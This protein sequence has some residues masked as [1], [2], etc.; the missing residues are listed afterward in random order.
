MSPRQLDRRRRRGR[1]RALPER[2]PRSS[3][4]LRCEGGGPRGNHGFT[5]AIP[6]RVSSVSPPSADTL[7]APGPPSTSGPGHGPFKAAARV[8]I[9]LGAWA[10][11]SVGR[12]P[13]LQAGGR[14]FEP[15]TAHKREPP[16]S[17]GLSSLEESATRLLG[18]RTRRRVRS[19]SSRL[20]ALCRTELS[21]DDSTGN[22]QYRAAACPITHGSSTLP[23][24]ARSRSR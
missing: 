2:S 14:R 23:A 12:A 4:R 19:A 15:V 24:R 20:L 7:V 10:V 17:R 11:S 22:T 5:R 6:A 13:A 18:A 9:P 3:E 21:G 16:G 1:S 8:R